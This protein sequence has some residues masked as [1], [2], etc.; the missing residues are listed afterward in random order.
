MSEA[1]P[2]IAVLDD[3]LPMRKA[4]RRL[5]SCH[6]YVVNEYAGGKEF[7]AALPSNPVDCLVLDLQMPEINGFDV[8]EALV[9]GSNTTPV[10]VITGHDEPGTSERVQGLGASSYLLKP[11][12]EA[13]LVYAIN[14]ALNARDSLRIGAI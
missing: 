11:V 4:L 6:G 12:D 3:E 13:E 14:S 1:P 9:F 5:L 10:V 2:V 7:L 8:L